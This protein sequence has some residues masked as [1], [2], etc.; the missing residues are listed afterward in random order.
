LEAATTTTLDVIATAAFY[1][2]FS[3]NSEFANQ[4][5]Q[6]DPLSNEASPVESISEASEFSINDLNYL[7]PVAGTDL[8]AFAA[9]GNGSII[10]W[11]GINFQGAGFPIT[12]SIAHSS[13]LT[14]E[15]AADGSPDGAPGPA[16]VFQWCPGPEFINLTIG[17]EVFSNIGCSF[18]EFMVIPV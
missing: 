2:Q 14:L 16:T 4:Y 5:L 1:L 18:V 8:F 12:C 3:S 13:P 11:V 7:F 17:N 15:C 9:S 6:L 10:R